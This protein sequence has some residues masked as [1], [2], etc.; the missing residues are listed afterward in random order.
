MTTSNPIATMSTW[1]N[2]TSTMLHDISSTYN[3][4]CYYLMPEIN[5]S[6]CTLILWV[7]IQ[8]HHTIILMFELQDSITFLLHSKKKEERG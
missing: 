2:N 6:M 5:A 4:S 8:A 7:T 3:S 1:M